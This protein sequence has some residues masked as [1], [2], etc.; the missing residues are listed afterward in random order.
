MAS[1]IWN[2]RDDRNVETVSFTENKQLTLD[3][4]AMLAR[5]GSKLCD[6][7]IQSKNKSRLCITT[8]L[9]RHRLVLPVVIMWESESMTPTVLQTICT[10]SSLQYS[11]ARIIPT[12]NECYSSCSSKQHFVSRFLCDTAGQ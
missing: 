9:D 1:E 6:L 2:E 7:E 4:W 8:W 5:C 3:F 11:P 12:R 10:K